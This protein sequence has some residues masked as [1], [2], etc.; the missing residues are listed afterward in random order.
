LSVVTLTVEVFAGRVGE[1]FQIDT[2]D[3]TVVMSLIETTRLG[4]ALQPE[5][6]APFSLEF[7]GPL[8][9]VLPQRTYRFEHDQLG[10]LEIFIV[11]LGPRD[12]RMRYEAVFA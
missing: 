8:E 6:R 2:G 12:D 4:V 3:G 7:L 9:P 5:G 1:T 11:P 10:E